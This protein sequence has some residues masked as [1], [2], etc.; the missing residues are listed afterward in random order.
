MLRQRRRDQ[1]ELTMTPRS[2]CSPSALTRRCGCTR[3]RVAGE[4][5]GCRDRDLHFSL[6]ESRGLDHNRRSGVRAYPAAWDS[7][8][9][10]SPASPSRQDHL[11]RAMPFVPAE[12]ILAIP[13]G[14]SHRPSS[15][16][17]QKK[18]A[19]AAMSS[20]SEQASGHQRDPRRAAVSAAY[21]PYAAGHYTD[22]LT[23]L[24]GWLLILG[25]CWSFFDGLAIAVRKSYFTMQPGHYSASHYCA[26]HWNL[27]A[28]GWANLILGMVSWP[29]AS[30]CSSA[31]LGHAGRVSCSRCSAAWQL[32]VPV[33]LP[34]L[35]HPGDRRRR[36]H[37]LGA[38]DRPPSAGRL[39]CRSAGIP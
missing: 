23:A 39:A 6:T 38:G 2:Q 20:E 30:A 37:H 18:G 34:V 8:P 1:Q 16:V 33:V 4:L 7:Y 15:R 24:P 10:R 11:H 25:G 26:Y 22:G 17:R 13:V 27:S 32:P 21:E 12:R 29:Q 28:W 36:R 14:H 3:R 9:A 31:R 5:C 19:V 35:V